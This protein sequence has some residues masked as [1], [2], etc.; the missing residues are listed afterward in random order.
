[1]E[2]NKIK[3]ERESYISNDIIE[4][5]KSIAKD[6]RKVVEDNYVVDWIN[7]QT[8]ASDIERAVFMM[9]N[10]NYFKQIKL[11][12]R[13]QMVLPLLNL[14]KKHFAVLEKN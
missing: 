13:K 14:A 1:V 8:K 6:I 2:E 12:I 11:N 7:N 3:E 10:K 5:S 4:L 9:L